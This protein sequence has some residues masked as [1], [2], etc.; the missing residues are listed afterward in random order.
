MN[1]DV[2]RANIKQKEAGSDPLKIQNDLRKV[3]VSFD[4][5]LQNPQ[6]ICLAKIHLHGTSIIL[7]TE[8]LCFTHIVPLTIGSF[9]P[10][11]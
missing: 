5:N 3:Q 7:M 9:S 4:L 1:C 8:D 2:K 10:R 6:K 11:Q